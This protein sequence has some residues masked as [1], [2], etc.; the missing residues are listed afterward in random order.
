MGLAPLST[1]G[2]RPSSPKVEAIL[3]AGKDESSAARKKKTAPSMPGMLRLERA[4]GA[5]AGELSA[6]A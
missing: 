2:L 4:V 5:P 6:A 3:A 1:I